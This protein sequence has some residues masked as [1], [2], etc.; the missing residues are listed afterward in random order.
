LHLTK[1]SAAELA[2]LNLC[3]SLLFYGMIVALSASNLAAA[4]PAAGGPT[5]TPA[6]IL[7][8]PSAMKPVAD[9]MPI[10]AREAFAKDPARFLS[11]TREILAGD[12]YLWLL[13]DKKHPL[14]AK[15]VASDLVKIAGHSPAVVANRADL[16]LR[17]PALDALVAMGN[18]ARRDGVSLEASSS[19]RSYE[20]QARLF[21][22]YIK[23]LGLAE[24]ERES[25]HAGMSQ[26][27]LGTAVDFGS[28]TPAFA[29]TKAG[30]WLSAN[31]WNYGWSISYP[32][33]AEA[34]TGYMYEAWHYRYVGK[35]ASDLIEH[36]FAGSQQAALVFLHENAAKLKNLLGLQAN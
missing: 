35:A 3:R 10:A 26:H 18:Q 16:L 25:A 29:K 2:A 28:V 22:G 30:K 5:S 11:L 31:A 21:S 8:E 34:Q 1:K 14:P 20:T 7:V 27:Q 36:Y 13:V 12:P 24:A 4:G 9:T 17:Q 23:E 19:Y 32:E 15:Y 33:G 6:T